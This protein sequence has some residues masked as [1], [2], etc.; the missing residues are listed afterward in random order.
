MRSHQM[1]ECH[2][3]SK[4]SGHTPRSLIYSLSPYL[5]NI[6]INVNVSDYITIIDTWYHIINIFNNNFYMKT[7]KFCVNDTFIASALE[8][9]RGDI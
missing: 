5:I 8:Y 1:V 4:P 9:I 6:L 2:V 7:S 3:I